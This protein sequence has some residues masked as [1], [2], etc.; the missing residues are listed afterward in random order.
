MGYGKHWRHTTHNDKQ[1]FIQNWTRLY[2]PESW[3]CLCYKLLTIRDWHD[4]CTVCYDLWSMWHVRKSH[5]QG[6]R[7]WPW[8]GDEDEGENEDEDDDDGD[9]DDDD[10]L[11][12]MLMMLMLMM[13][14]ML[15]LMMMVW[16]CGDV[17]MWFKIQV[18]ERKQQ[19]RS[20][21]QSW[22]FRVSSFQSRHGAVF[23]H[24]QTKNWRTPCAGKWC[25][26]PSGV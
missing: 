20:E 17:V 18:K 7:W 12:L 23:G 11:M 22:K 3:R 14:M 26:D 13:L 8:G 2:R 9:G 21:G 16:W 1:H 4:C 19:V 10:L 5:E 25:L 15:L 6:W 24:P